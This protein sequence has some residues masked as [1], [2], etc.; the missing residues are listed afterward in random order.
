METNFKVFSEPKEIYD[1][2]INDINSST[3]SV[4]LET[5]IFRKDSVGKRFLDALTLKA[6]E[7]IK[8]KLLLDAWGT[9]LKKSYFSKFIK[10]GGEL[11]KVR[12]LRYVFNWFSKNHER[13]HKKL[14][15]V[16][17]KITYVGSCN[18]TAECLNWRELVLRLDGEISKR[19]KKFFYFTWE[20]A[21]IG[22]NLKDF[23]QGDF[24][25]LYD[26]PSSPFRNVENRYKELI[27]GAK[28]EICIETPYFVPSFIV[29]KAIY[30]AIKRGVKVRILLPYVGDVKIM[31]IVRNR[32]INNLYRKK[33]KIYFFS[34]KFSHAKLLIVDKKFFLLGSSNLD[35][36]SFIHQYEI[37]ILG[38]DK[39][40]I[41][42]LKRF[43]E[44][45]ID[46]SFKFNYTLFKSRFSFT[47]FLEKFLKKFEKY[48]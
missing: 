7:G 38:K 19:F 40:I 23:L 25:I 12:E 35:Y 26:S 20:S 47:K 1:S 34:P 22:E 16:D 44:N 24:Q 17:D 31:D 37:N 9:P 10:S 3:E 15:I 27:D 13:D 11:K 43:F 21:K 29:R 8:V 4:L 36:R 28:K 46:Q 2:M 32:Y 42:S 39:K 5:Y 18:I 30:R 6:K 14:L 48:L 41:R 33:A 45:G